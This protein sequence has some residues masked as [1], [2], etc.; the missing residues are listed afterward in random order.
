MTTRKLNL[1]LFVIGL[2]CLMIIAGCSNT[3]GNANSEDTGSSSKNKPKLI[4]ATNMTDGTNPQNMG[5]I[6]EYVE[7]NKDKVD[8][9]IQSTAGED[10]R[11]KIQVD[12]VSNSLPDVFMYWAGAATMAP[13]IAADLVLDISEYIDASSKTDWNDWSDGVK[14]WAQSGGIHY[15]LPNGAGTGF[16]LINKEIYDEYNLKIPTTYQEWTEANQVL[17]ENGIIPFAMGSVGGNPSH[18][19]F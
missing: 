14:E 4:F 8:I 5:F 1:K 19:F 2:I 18:H 11:K 15:M 6:K 9:Q 12:M 13:L 16:F 3:N 7:A 17:S 10:H